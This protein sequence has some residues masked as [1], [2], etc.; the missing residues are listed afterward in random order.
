MSIQIA[1]AEALAAEAVA[2]AFTPSPPV[3]FKEW[4]SKNILF[5]GGGAALPGYYN[6]EDFPYYDDILD[7][8]GPDD[9]C[10]IV[11]L[12]K[13][14]QV[15]ATTLANV[16]LMG[17]MA[18]DPCNFLFVHP[19]EENARRWSKQKFAEMLKASPSMKAVFP[20]RS[21]DQS[22]SILYKETADGRGIIQAASSNSAAGLSQITMRKQVQDDLSKWEVNSA[23]DPE[24]QADSRSK[25]FENAKIF[26]ISTPL[27]MPGCRITN[28]Y[29]QGSCE[30]YHMPCPR[31]AHMQVLEWENF[32]ATIRD[33]APERAHFTCVSCA[34][35]IEDHHRQ[36]MRRAGKWVAQF[37]E[38]MRW[39]RSFHIWTAYSKLQSFELLARDWIAARGNT[40]TEKVFLNDSVGIAFNAEGDAPPS[41]KLRERASAARMTRGI[42]PADGV[43]LTIGVDCQLHG[44]HWQA[45]AWMR[46]GRRH[47]VDCG[48]I[49]GHISDEFARRDLDALLDRPFV[50]EQGPRLVADR[51]CIDGN[52]YTPDVWEWVK[53]KPASRVAMVRGVDG[54]G[55]AT[56][57]DQVKREVDRN[58][59]KIPWSKRFYNFSTSVMKLDLYRNLPKDDPIQ[60]G[61]IGFASDLPDDYFDELTSERRVFTKNRRGFPVYAWTLPEGA[62]NE[63]LDTHLQAYTAALMRGLRSMTD[64]EW[65]HLEALR[66]QPPAAAQLDFE[67]L[68]LAQAQVPA[69]PPQTPATPPRLTF[70]E[71]ARKA[72]THSTSRL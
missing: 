24:T 20:E 41:D 62:R 11:S 68:P 23:G 17:T 34:E 47:V 12:A 49:G 56:L 45:V 63:M 18:L 9:P 28:S 66:C 43:L 65:N 60:P 21:R 71:M 44:L 6:R 16:F 61:Y 33:D 59:K 67:D 35:P 7:A 3:D 46:D 13:S 27:V 42:V 31:C 69:P 52:A 40:D 30:R 55:R 39:H 10:R 53:R 8:L 29:N 19:S 14:A 22:E 57:Y 38:R 54:E 48:V 4:A 32:K 50:H 26:K 1:N 25:A 64:S 51:L 72:N 5:E 37:P 15:G 2:L 70:A 36:A 58:G